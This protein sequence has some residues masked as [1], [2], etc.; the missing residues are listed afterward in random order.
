[1][2][3]V[4]NETTLDKDKLMRCESDRILVTPAM[5]HRGECA[6]HKLRIAEHITLWDWLR[7]KLKIIR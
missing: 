2:K 5:I 3:L 7:W 4:Y 6:G 1:M